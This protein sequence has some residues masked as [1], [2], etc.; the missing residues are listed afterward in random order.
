MET[1]I[2]RDAYA[3]CRTSFGNRCFALLIA[4]GLLAITLPSSEGQQLPPPFNSSRTVEGEL[5]VKFKGGT[6][7]LA[8]AK[9]Q[10][11]FKHQVKRHFD[12]IGWQHIRLPPGMTEA[13]ALAKY[14]RHP[15]VLAV[16]PNYVFHSRLANTNS[17]VTSNDPRF[18]EQ[19]A[20]AKI[21]ATNAWSLT[22]G[23]SN[24]VVAV[25]DSGVRYNHEDLAANMWRNLNEI[26]GNGIDDDA[27]GYV[28]DVYG[29]DAVSNDSDP[30]DDRIS[31]VYHGTACA[32]IIGAVGNNG[33]GIAGLNWSV[34]VM[35]LRLAATSNFIASAWMVE[36]FEYVLAMK[37]RGVNI[38]VTSNSYGGDDAP[39]LAVR[40]AIDAA[41]NAG[42]LNVFAAGNSTT[43]L[44]VRCDYP[45]CFRLASMINVAAS[46]LA[47]NL[48][49]FSN[50]GATNVDLAAPGVNIVTTDGITTNSYNPIFAGTS[51]SAPFVAGAAALLASAYPSATMVEIKRALM[52][53]VDVL[54]AFTNKVQSGG[55]L[56]VGRAIQQAILSTSAPPFIL[57]SP[58]SQIVGLGYPA[59]FRVIATGAAPIDYFWRFN[60]A[61]FA[62][63]TE[64]MLTMPSV[65]LQNSGEYSVVLSN[66]FGMA[67]SAVATLTVVTEPTILAQPQGMRVRDG[68][69]ISLVVVAAGGAPLIYQW[70]RNSQNIDGATSPCLALT[71][72]DWTMSGDYQ[73]ILSN[74]YGTR[75]SAVA[76]VTVLTRPH[77]A[78]QPQSQTVAVGANV[79]LSVTVTNTA[80]LPLG[81]FWLRDG[82][83]AGLMVFSNPFTAVTNF[84][85]IQTNAAGRWSVAMSNEAPSGAST[86]FSSNAY[87]TVVLPPTNQSALLGSSV[88]LTALAVGPAPLRYQWQHAGTNLANATSPN[89]SLT[90]VQAAEGGSYSV[91][92]TNAIGQ[93]AIFTA[94][95]QVLVVPRP[96]L[97]EPR[98]LGDGTFQ[99]VLQGLSNQQPYAVEISSN[100]LNWTVLKTFTAT[101]SSVPFADVIASEAGPRFYRARSDP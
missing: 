85:N 65:S 95:L 3:N 98:K 16:E 17:A 70:Q 59:T 77:L 101:N 47:D 44:D 51:A 93:P 8:A 100:L 12:R 90:N 6:R 64:P 89:L 26:P 61:Q 97:T 83:P 37:A 54:P 9:A 14:G 99:M 73:A 13:E 50:Y 11:A 80:T 81:G 42:I 57:T 29:I 4:L 58:E 18:T 19:W 45:A 82:R 67:T 68:T 41:G 74:G 28:D 60:G 1:N 15:D 10:Q 31:F 20:L 56:N 7:G 40:D 36:C 92:I 52:E 76:R 27:N 30:V 2:T 43:N 72:V 46:D 22:T 79:S 84:Q 75:T 24:V 62:Q 32:G 25:L 66:A 39:S 69:N 96:L 35:A 63:T 33:V 86:I 94:N 55:R 91:V 53:S 49:A 78:A 38:R 88:T 5:L 71:N 87:L 21:G 34:Q 23:R 48:A